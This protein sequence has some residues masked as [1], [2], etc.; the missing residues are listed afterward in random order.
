MNLTSIFHLLIIPVTRATIKSTLIKCEKYPPLSK[1]GKHG[2]VRV[3]LLEKK[4]FESIICLAWKLSLHRV[5]VV[6]AMTAVIPCFNSSKSF[7]VL[8]CH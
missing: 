4:Q 2:C 8:R 6:S 7:S 1:S 3:V 5:G